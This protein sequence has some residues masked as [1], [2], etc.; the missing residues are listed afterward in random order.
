M[1]SS[2]ERPACFVPRAGHWSCARDDEAEFPTPSLGR[3]C[4]HQGQSPESIRSRCAPGAEQRPRNA[5]LRISQ[6]VDVLSPVDS[7]VVVHVAAYGDWPDPGH[8]TRTGV[9]ETCLLWSHGLRERGHPGLRVA[10]GRGNRAAHHAPRAMA[11]SS[12]P[13]WMVRTHASSMSWPGVALRTWGLGVG[14]PCGCRRCPAQHPNV[15]SCPLASL[16]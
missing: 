7:V 4:H 6:I 13:M 8:G 14:P 12:R 16:A 2:E 1:A 5:H 11:A 9:W 3:Q 10:H 15:C